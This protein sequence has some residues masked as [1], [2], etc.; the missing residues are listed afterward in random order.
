M[1]ILPNLPYPYDALEPFIDV[2]TMEIHH[3]KHHQSYVDKLN[4][5]LKD[6]PD[7]LKINVEEILKNI[8]KVPED[9]RQKVIN[10]GGGHVNHSF[11]W[12]SMAPKATDFDSS[13]FDPYKEEFIQKAISFF[14]SG[15]V[16]LVK[17]NGKFEIMTTSNQE[18]PLAQGKVP[19][20]CLD[21]W[22]HAYY[23]KYQNKR[24]DYINAWFNII[25]WQEAKNIYT[26]S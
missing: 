14:G 11:F 19:V 23:L 12:K 22:E 16:W 6:Y 3:T 25:N 9:I 1:F 15:W 4:E 21:L 7:F 24:A 20:L 18:S 26:Q 10:F 8:D 17:S 13:W 5:T 2:R